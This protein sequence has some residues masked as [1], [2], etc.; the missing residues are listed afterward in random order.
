[1]REKPNLRIRDGIWTRSRALRSIAPP[2]EAHAIVESLRTGPRDAS[3]PLRID[4][5]LM[6]VDWDS[7]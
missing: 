2:V 1:L 3:H 4:F 7:G 5:T 6:K